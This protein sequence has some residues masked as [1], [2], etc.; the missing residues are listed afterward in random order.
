ML[1]VYTYKKVKNIM[2]ILKIAGIVGLVL[3]ATVG[4]FNVE[5]AQAS[6]APV[7]SVQFE[8]GCEL[9]PM[10]CIAGTRPPLVSDKEVMLND[11]LAG[12]S[13]QA[14]ATNATSCT[15][16][17]SEWGMI[18]PSYVGKTI[19]NFPGEQFLSRV[20]DGITALGTYTFKV[21]CIGPG[22]NG[23]GSATLRV[24][25]PGPSDTT[26]KITASK[27]SIKDGESVTLSWTSTNAG[28]CSAT[29]RWQ[30]TGGQFSNS[31]GPTGSQIVGPLSSSGSPYRFG[32]TCA[33]ISGFKA[34]PVSV[35]T[36]TVK[37]D[38]PVIS[39]INTSTPSVGDTVTV[40]GS[41][42]NSNTMVVLD[43]GGTSVTPTF[44]SSTSLS[45]VIPKYTG[46]G[47]GHDFIIGV[48]KLQ[49][50]NSGGCYSGGGVMCDFPLSNAVTFNVV[51]VLQ[52]TH[53]SIV[54]PGG[55]RTWKIGST[56]TF[57]WKT[58]RV[59]ATATGYITFASVGYGGE[60]VI[61]KKIADNIPNT[62]SFT[63]ASVGKA[64]DG[65]LIPASVYPYGFIVVMNVPDIGQ[66]V[67]DYKDRTITLSDVN[68]STAPTPA[69][70]QTPASTSGS[71]QVRAGSD[72]SPI[73]TTAP[74]QTSTNE[75]LQRQLVQLITQLLQLVQQAASKGILTSSQ[76][77][78]ILGSIQM[79]R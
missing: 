11:N 34:M 35:V 72:T 18:Y 56:Q 51:P 61:N 65:S 15:L 45:F 22:G 73:Q 47:I 4:V 78:S 38:T 63:W 5:R 75:A 31:G 48:H 36:V 23:T 39:T 76:V 74:V 13:I 17:G 26:A 49:L 40:K 2:K 9:L 69:P 71:D 59:P 50:D 52:N 3:V 19:S 25:A 29:E 41:N 43:N 77:L 8:G 60:A 32:I 54:E 64:A 58:E 67:S 20:F 24:V 57:T 33:P 21:D 10:G 68:G 14:S 37:S 30:I 53:L 27:Y 1:V 6:S 7:V 55:Y 79:P 62:G 46:S 12:A 16:V 42:F 44:I 28:S 70:T 66:K